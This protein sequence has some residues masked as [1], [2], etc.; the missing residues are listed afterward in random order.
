MIKNLEE[1]LILDQNIKKHKRETLVDFCEKL[2][3][4]GY[5][6]SFIAGILGNI[7]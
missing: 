4:Y 7:K 3:N 6:P 5:E 2:L 1:K